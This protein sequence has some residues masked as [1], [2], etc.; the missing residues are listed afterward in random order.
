VPLYIFLQISDKGTNFQL[1][2]LCCFLDRVLQKLL[3]YPLDDQLSN[4][5]VD[6]YKKISIVQLLYFSLPN[7]VNEQNLNMAPIE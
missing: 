3:S 5:Y 7:G 6:C 4:C 2:S 1:E